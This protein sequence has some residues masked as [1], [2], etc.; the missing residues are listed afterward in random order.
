VLV[1]D[2]VLEA[3]RL[4]PDSSSHGERDVCGLDLE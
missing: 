2:P 4:G 1:G 3:P